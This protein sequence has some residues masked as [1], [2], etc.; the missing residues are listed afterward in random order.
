MEVIFDNNHVGEMISSTSPPATF[1]HAMFELNED[2]QEKKHGCVCRVGLQIVQTSIRAV[3]SMGA[4]DMMAMSSAKLIGSIA[5]LMIGIS[6][7]GA[8][9]AIQSLRSVHTIVVLL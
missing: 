5:V 1:A 2:V 8:R 9:K 7:D 3:A 4:C 6:S